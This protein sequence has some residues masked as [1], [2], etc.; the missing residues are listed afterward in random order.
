MYRVERKG[1]AETMLHMVQEFLQNIGE[2]ALLFLGVAFALEWVLLFF[3]ERRI[4]AIL[5]RKK[6]PFLSSLLGGAFGALTPL[7][8]Y[9]SVPLAIVFLRL[10]IPFEAIASFLFVS[11]LLNPILASFLVT[12]F[13][14]QRALLYI[15]LVFSQTVLLGYFVSRASGAFWV[16][17][18]CVSTLSLGNAT[19][20]KSTLQEEARRIFS[21]MWDLARSIFPFLALGSAL[22]V[23]VEF[24]LPQSILFRVFSPQD[25]SGIFWV[26]LLGI[27][28][29]LRGEFVLPLGKALLEKGMNPGIIVA[30]L[31]SGAGGV[32]I[33]ELALMLSAFRWRFVLAFALLIFLLAVEMGFIF[34]VLGN[35]A[36]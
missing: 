1:M 13:G 15:V 21:G 26:S 12:L 29:Y 24:F 11:P 20:A 4:E 16:R 31:V 5:L 36:G 25:P 19:N 3:P 22:G 27:P 33:P 34:F 30:F 35:I 28:L 9:S 23:I 10:G 14:W 7:C 18:N 2:L 17:E 8:S 6:S 32:S